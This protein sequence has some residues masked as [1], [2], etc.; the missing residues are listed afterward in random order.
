MSFSSG[1]VI[2]AL[3]VSRFVTNEVR[4]L[5]PLAYSMFANVHT[6]QSI[7][8]RMKMVRDGA[9]RKYLMP[10]SVYHRR[11]DARIEKGGLS[12]TTQPSGY[13]SLW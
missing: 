9:N 8:S 5:A 4:T 2:A 1:V 10:R 7:M 12:T 6:A 13:S 3:T 11:M